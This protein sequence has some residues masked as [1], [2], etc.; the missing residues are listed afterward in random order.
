[1]GAPAF[2]AM[3]LAS[4][5]ALM[6]AAEVGD[7]R[8]LPGSEAVRQQMVGLLKQ[9]VAR[10]REAGIPD[11]E[12]AEARYAIVA[13]IDDR[14]L[15]SNWPGRAEWQSNPLQ[16]QFFREFT[17]GENF[18]AR[19]T[20]LM[21]R[22]DPAY[23]LEVYYLCLALGFGGA[24]TRGGQ[25]SSQAYLD[26]ARPRVLA[27][28]APDRIAPNAIPPERHRAHPRPFPIIGATVLVCALMGVLG[29][30]GLQIG[31]GR[32]IDRA[33]D[34]TRAAGQKPASAEVR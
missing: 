6:T 31:L 32:V 20:A 28:R 30:M 1:M 21:K 9:L 2:D 27:G 16:L 26:S 33:R 10:S 34:A 14:I 7:G 15:K 19:M 18:F 17:A 24:S 29:L 13:F 25:N 8:G 3:Y 22:G 12:T 23:A 4:V 5:D 11:A